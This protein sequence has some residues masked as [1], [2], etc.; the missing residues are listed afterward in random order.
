VVS[1][2]FL[3]TTSVVYVHFGGHLVSASACLAP[4]GLMLVDDA[5]G[6]LALRSPQARRLPSPP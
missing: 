1:C 5:G 3:P 4:L 6:R 2:L